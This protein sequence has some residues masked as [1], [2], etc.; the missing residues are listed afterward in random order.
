MFSN[1]SQSHH[2]EPFTESRMREVRCSVIG[3]G[4]LEYSDPTTWA[5]MR[6]SLSRLEYVPCFYTA[7]HGTNKMARTRGLRRLWKQETPPLPG[8]TNHHS[9]THHLAVLQTTLS[10]SLKAGSCGWKAFFVHQVV[11][12]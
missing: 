7:N 12:V 10:S 2:K 1:S 6:M 3:L 11:R 9:L 4:G 8:T 5:D